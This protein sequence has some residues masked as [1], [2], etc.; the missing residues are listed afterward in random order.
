VLGE[1]LGAG[2]TVVVPAGGTAVVVGSRTRTVGQ[3]VAAGAGLPSYRLS[4]LMMTGVARGDES[5]FP[6]TYRPE[7]RAKKGIALKAL[8]TIRDPA[9]VSSGKLKLNTGWI[10]SLAVKLFLVKV[11]VVPEVKRNIT[12]RVDGLIGILP[13]LKTA[14]PRG[15]AAFSTCRVVI[16]RSVMFPV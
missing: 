7:L 9:I 13:S 10:N 8:G 2:T 14:R 1:G 16:R 3:E 6:G 15:G 11:G 4:C 12:L 5:G